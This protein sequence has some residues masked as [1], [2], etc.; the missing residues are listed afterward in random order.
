LFLLTGECTIGFF[1]ILFKLRESKE[2]L[3]DQNDQAVQP[4]FKKWQKKSPEKF[5]LFL[6]TI[7]CPLH[8]TLLRGI[9]INLAD[10]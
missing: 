10:F 4:H 2:F 7:A 9:E 5:S 8:P 6:T 1:Q 3:T